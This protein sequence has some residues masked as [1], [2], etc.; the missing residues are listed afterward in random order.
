MARL[1]FKPAANASSNRDERIEIELSPASTLLVALMKNGVPIRH[2]CGGRTICG[3]CRV[4]VRAATGNQAVGTE[5]EASGTG[6]IIGTN[7]F[8]T[9][10]KERLSALGLKLDG[11]I[12]LACRLVSAVDIEA[13]GLVPFVTG[14]KG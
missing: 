2:D 13:E 6:R 5:P 14:G 8:G 7:P 1:R 4:A 9:Q 3:T 10:E 11:S 12:R